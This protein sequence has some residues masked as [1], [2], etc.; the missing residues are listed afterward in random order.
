MRQD[1]KD[2]LD[3][4]AKGIRVE[5]KALADITNLGMEQIISRQDK[6]NG[7]L[8]TLEKETR[9][10]RYIQT[11]P[12]LATMLFVVCMI[13]VIVIIDTFSLGEVIRLWIFKA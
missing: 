11:H 10:A 7:T 6:A 13:V 8:V 5:I 3:E 2:Y 1:D 9:L 12:R 4:V